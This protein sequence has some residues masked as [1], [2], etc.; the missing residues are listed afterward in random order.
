MNRIY[1]N[2]W[3]RKFSFVMVC[4]GFILVTAGAAHATGQISFTASL[5][6]GSKILW[7][8]WPLVLLTGLS[9]V[10]VLVGD[11]YVSSALNEINKAADSFQ[12]YLRAAPGRATIEDSV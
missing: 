6:S 12:D 4:V 5:F 7:T 1:E 10:L 9:V 3:D 2:A 11:T 8:F